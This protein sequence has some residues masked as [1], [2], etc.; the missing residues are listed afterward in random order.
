VASCAWAALV[1]LHF[2]IYKIFLAHKYKNSSK[3]NGDILTTP[4]FN[5]TV[6]FLGTLMAGPPLIFNSISSKAGLGYLEHI[7]TLMGAELEEVR[8]VVD[9]RISYAASPQFLSLHIWFNSGSLA[10]GV[11]QFLYGYRLKNPYIHRILGSLYV[12]GFTLGCA[13]GV[14]YLSKWGYGRLEDN[15]FG[16]M[17]AF[18][19]MGS[20]V[21][22]PAYV[23]VYQIVVN[24]NYLAHREWMSRSIGAALGAAVLFRIFIIRIDLFSPK[25]QYT[26]YLL[27]GYIAWVTGLFL[28]ELHIQNNRNY[29]LGLLWKGMGFKDEGSLNRLLSSK[30]FQELARIQKESDS[31]GKTNEL[32]SNELKLH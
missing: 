18:T 4:R 3:G 12:V 25:N 11:F 23:A 1:G 29:R 30:H 26:Y 15:N 8:L 14:V 16:S 9:E 7:Y 22:I 5:W 27:T 31:Y 10:I 17:I 24:K 19:S 6:A 20:A 21:C 28:A 2:L 13:F 32:R